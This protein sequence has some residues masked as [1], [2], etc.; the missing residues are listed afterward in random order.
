LQVVQCSN[1]IPHLVKLPQK[2]QLLVCSL[3]QFCPV[4]AKGLELVDEFIH[5]IPQ[6]LVSQLHI[7]VSMQNDL[8]KVAVIVPRITLLLKSGL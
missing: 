4:L 8:E 2:G 6:P 3:L 5:H 1:N 7:H